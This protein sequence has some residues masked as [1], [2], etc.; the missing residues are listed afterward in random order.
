[1][2]CKS[3]GVPEKELLVGIGSIA[4]GWL[5]GA[6]GIFNRGEQKLFRERL[7]QALMCSMG[8]S[9]CHRDVVPER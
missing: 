6:Q 5:S 9:F 7:G 4:L 1:M 2:A 8:V 3:F